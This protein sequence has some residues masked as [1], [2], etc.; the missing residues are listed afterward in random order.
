MPTL[1]FPAFKIDFVSK[2]KKIVAYILS[3]R[4]NLSK[5]KAEF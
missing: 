4:K 2:K 3:L 1:N 5:N